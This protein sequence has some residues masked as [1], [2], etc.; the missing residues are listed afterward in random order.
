MDVTME[1]KV[2]LRGPERHRR[3]IRRGGGEARRRV[4]RKRRGGR[5]RR[6]LYS[7]FMPLWRGNDEFTLT[8][9]HLFV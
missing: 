1:A 2:K 8:L 4:R 5:R 6:N 7:P 9:K 3:R